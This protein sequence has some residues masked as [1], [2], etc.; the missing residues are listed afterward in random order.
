MKRKAFQFIEQKR[1]SLVKNTLS[2]YYIYNM[3]GERGKYRRK[4]LYYKR[5]REKFPK[6]E[7]NKNFFDFF[8]VNA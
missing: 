4:W 8:R 7:K 2:Y 6:F 1:N 3:E 5:K